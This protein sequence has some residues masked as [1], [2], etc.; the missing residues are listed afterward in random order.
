MQQEQ[1]ATSLQDRQLAACR[2]FYNFE[3][4]IPMSVIEV[5]EPLE[6]TRMYGPFS[7]EVMLWTRKMG[8]LVTMGWD[9]NGK[10]YIEY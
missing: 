5:E 8:S 4:L 1:Y 3:P 6:K 10:E 7:L 2:D 9:A